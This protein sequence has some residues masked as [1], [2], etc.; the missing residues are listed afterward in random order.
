MRSWRI[1][2]K[3]ITKDRNEALHSFWLPGP[4][5]TSVRFGRKAD[6]SWLAMRQWAD[7]DLRALGNRIDSAA[8]ELVMLGRSGLVPDR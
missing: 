3:A 5:P 8:H 7:D 2:A 6:P 1:Q 4:D